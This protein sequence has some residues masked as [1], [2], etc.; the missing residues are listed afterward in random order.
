MAEFS[1]YF[2][3][4]TLTETAPDKHCSGIN[5]FIVCFIMKLLCFDYLEKLFVNL[6]YNINTNNANIP[7]LG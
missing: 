2:W 4:Y 1:A 7:N 6:L 3:I 5:K